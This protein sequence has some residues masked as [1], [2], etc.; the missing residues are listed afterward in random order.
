[1]MMMMKWLSMNKEVAC[2]K[3]VK[4][5]NTV[6]L[7]SLGKCLDIVEIKWFNTIKEMYP[8]KY[9]LGRLYRDN[10]VSIGKQS[11]KL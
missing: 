4:T 8:Y 10:A 1:M 6:H 2:R 5:T 11:Q 3:I 7:Q 9:K